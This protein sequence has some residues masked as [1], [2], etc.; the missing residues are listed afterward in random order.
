VPEPVPAPVPYAPVPIPVPVPEPVPIPVPVPEPVPI[1]RPAP[2]PIPAPAPYSHSLTPHQLRDITQNSDPNNP[3]VGSILQQI[4]YMLSLGLNLS[5]PNIQR[6]LQEFRMV[7]GF[8]YYIGYVP[9]TNPT[10]INPSTVPLTQNMINRLRPIVTELEY[11][12]NIGFNPNV[13]LY[14]NDPWAIRRSEFIEITGYD[15]YNEFSLP[16]PATGGTRKRS[17]TLKKSKKSKTRKH[18]HV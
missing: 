8:P 16:P 18:K 12:R 14:F 7:T 13:Y 9:P 5:S 4:L 1:P 3:Q 17:K 15:Y 2:A 6:P 11:L 10:I